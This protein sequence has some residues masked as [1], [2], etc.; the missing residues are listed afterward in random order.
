MPLTQIAGT[1]YPALAREFDAWLFATA[2]NLE[3]IGAMQ[4][5][6]IPAEQAAADQVLE[7]ISVE[8]LEGALAAIDDA[9]GPDP[10]LDAREAALARAVTFAMFDAFW[11]GVWLATRGLAVWPPVVTVKPV[12]TKRSP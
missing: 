10:D 7:A 1:A 6:V 3:P 2:E 11:F 5:V 12:E 8:G 9:E 4:A